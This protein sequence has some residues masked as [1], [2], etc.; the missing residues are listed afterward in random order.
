MTTAIFSTNKLEVF[1][2]KNLAVEAVEKK[3]LA[4]MSQTN[5]ARITPRMSQ[6]LELLKDGNTRLKPRGSLEISIEHR[7][8]TTSLP[9]PR[10]DKSQPI[11]RIILG[12]DYRLK[13][14]DIENHLKEIQSNPSLS[15]TAKKLVRPALL[16]FNNKKEQSESFRPGICAVPGCSQSAH[17]SEHVSWCDAHAQQMLLPLQEDF[18]R[19][20]KTW[21]IHIQEKLESFER[22]DLDQS[23][24]RSLLYGKLQDFLRREISIQRSSSN[25][26]IRSSCHRLLQAISTYQ[27]RFNPEPFSAELLLELVFAT[28]VGLSAKCGAVAVFSSTAAVAIPCVFIGIGVWRRELLLM[29]LGFGA[30]L[31]VGVGLLLGGPVGAAAGAA[32]GT[33]LVGFSSIKELTQENNYT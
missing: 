30:A 33:G 24:I 2:H 5:E 17:T 4:S 11:E 7:S 23:E 25:D 20:V 10:L 15:I 32:I 27:D 9:P 13:D 1:D 14:A 28:L 26:E 31:G 16:F 6:V 21:P 19:E 3:P 18:K 8:F 12:E 22:V 29:K